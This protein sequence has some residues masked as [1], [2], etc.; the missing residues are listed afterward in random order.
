MVRSGGHL[1]RVIKFDASSKI[2]DSVGSLKVLIPH[3]KDVLLSGFFFSISSQSGEI[4]YE[5]QQRGF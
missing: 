2:I 3:L 5:S 4:C 1:L